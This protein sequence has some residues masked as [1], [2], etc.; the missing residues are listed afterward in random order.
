MSRS[1]Q[2]RTHDYNVVEIHKVG[3]RLLAVNLHGKM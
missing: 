2:A 1:V 3:G